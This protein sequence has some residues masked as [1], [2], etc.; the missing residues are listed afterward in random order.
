MTTYQKSLIWAGSISLDS[1]F[2]PMA[3][4]DAGVGGGEAGAGE[5]DLPGL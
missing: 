1:T 5:A 3:G 4:E 2:I